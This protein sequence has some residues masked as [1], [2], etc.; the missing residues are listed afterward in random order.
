VTNLQIGKWH[1]G[2]ERRIQLMNASQM[3]PSVT[4][5]SRWS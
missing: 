3:Q 4:T 1:P 2:P 5:M